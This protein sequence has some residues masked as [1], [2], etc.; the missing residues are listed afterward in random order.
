MNRIVLLALALV[1][2]GCHRVELALP[3][4]ETLTLSE[5]PSGRAAAATC[6]LPPGSEQHSRFLQWLESHR[7]GWSQSPATYVP[8]LR[9][10][11]TGFEVNVL[12][13]IVVIIYS[14]GQYVA[15]VIEGD[16]L[17]LKCER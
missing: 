4:D 3:V 15:T 1:P 6:S 13:E 16:E 9:I 2:F 17:T 5:V 8:G 12:P 11:G 14:E 10:K 7:N